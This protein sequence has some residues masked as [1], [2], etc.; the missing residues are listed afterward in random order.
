MKLEIN[1]VFNMDCLKGMKKLEDNSVDLVVTDPPYGYGFMGKDW[2]KSVPS[3]DVW[4]E[5]LRVLKLG[6]FAF[7]MSTPRSDEVSLDK[8]I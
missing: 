7:I 6:G 8:W 1:K 3:V 2:D 5:C 4:K